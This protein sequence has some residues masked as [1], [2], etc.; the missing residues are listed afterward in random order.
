[1]S[2]NVENLQAVNLGADHATALA[3]ALPDGVVVLDRNG[4]VT[5]VSDR[6]CLITGYS[7]DECVGRP[8]PHPWWPD[9]P[10]GRPHEGREATLR[11]RSGEPLP[12]LVV[13][14]RV[15]TGRDAS[16]WVRLVRDLRPQAEAAEQAS[17][18]RVAM[19]A[20]T[21]RDPLRV[22]GVAA[23][24]VAELLAV[25]SGLVCR[26]D[27]E[28]AEV[29]GGHRAEG[30]PLPERVPLT[31]GS[32]LAEV[33]LTGRPA[34][35][36][37][38]EAA[39]P[40][41]VAGRLWGAL[42]VSSSGE[43]PVPPDAERRLERFCEVVAAGLEAAEAR[44]RLAALA[45]TDSLTGL[46]NHRAFH[47]RLREEVARARRHGRALSLC[48][49]DL[50][51]FKRV[52]DL[53]GHQAGDRAL[54]D[55]ARRLEQVA[56]A[57]DLVARVGGEELAWIL[58]ETDAHNALEAVE[59]ARRLVA[60]TPLAGVA[61]VTISAGICDLTWACDADDLVRL[62]DAALYWAK[63]HGRDLACRYAPGVVELSPEERARGLERSQAMTALCSLARAVD[64]KDRSTHAHSERVARLAE[65]IALAMGWTPERAAGLRDAG[66]LHDLG[67]IGVPDAVLFATG[68]LGD[69]EREQ[70]RR[71]A[72][73]GAE[74]A[75]DALGA[76]QC[77]WIRGHHERF[78]G[79]G[80]PDRLAGEEIP[81]GARILAVADA[82]DAI[83]H[84]RAAGG[85]R[86]PAAELRAGA[87]TQ[88]CPRVVAAA[89][90]VAGAEPAGAPA[91]ARPPG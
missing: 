26:L 88:F 14:R 10:G 91:S 64:A 61:P 34:R 16:G 20:A 7:R 75:G 76:E 63:A 44:A 24:E 57:G 66:L 82:W 19:A 59:R 81:E 28:G 79:S 37:D 51:H 12:A 84:A 62:A 65:R 27:G 2:E 73:L 15:G 32:A 39:A 8:A 80:Y 3:S 33:A 22:I 67:K 85:P 23:R 9:E 5:E 48:L 83:A 46:A 89:L 71:H 74:I 42:A 55:L 13:D 78:D 72:A 49:L 53:H 18:R 90:A 54:V 21:G 31:P 29:V 38:H 6:F 1:M 77:A 4:V 58:P 40:V 36:G 56:R 87:G 30:G 68:P 11:T 52:N 43:R 35:V 25:R 60:G 47:E 17:L 45:V 69:A 70:M 41:R 50:D 86:D